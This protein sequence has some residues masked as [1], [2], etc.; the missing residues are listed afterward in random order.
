MT[1][2]ELRATQNP[3]K[4]KYREQPHAALITLRAEGNA[5]Q[6]VTC[7]L[8]TGKSLATAG[9]HPSTGGSGLQVC[10]GDM[11]LEALVACAGVTLTAVAT[12]LGIALRGARIAA[13]GDLDVRGTLSVS[14]DVPVGIQ[15]IRLRFKLD[16]EASNDQLDTLIR[17]TERYCVVFQ[18]LK[19]P[20][21][22]TIAREM[23]AASA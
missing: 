21:E 19:S 11:L 5:G 20:P 18:T 1:S 13:E 6:G 9:L 14:K 2:D 8:S 12:S 23:S 10:A 16:T 7:Q 22:I 3:L 17:L 4:S 15:R